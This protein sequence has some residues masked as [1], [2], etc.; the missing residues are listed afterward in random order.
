MKKII[1]IA[2][3]LIAS[4]FVNILNSYAENKM[5]NSFAIK[6]WDEALYLELDNGT[7]YSKV[8][9]VKEYTGEL[10]GIGHLEYLMAYNKAGDA[11]FTGIEHFEG[12]IDG[13]VGS[14]ATIHEGMFKE[15]TVEASF[16]IIKNSQNG[17][18]TQLTGT[19]NYKTGHSM[20][21]DFHF[22]YSFAEK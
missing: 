17:E 2:I 1:I 16:E 3:A 12:S 18:L 14:F 21:V 20:T 4:L 6:S 8:K 5:K 7:K 22:N 9:L 11:T 15:G 10:K 13:Y 19:G